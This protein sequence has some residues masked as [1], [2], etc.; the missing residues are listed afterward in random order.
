MEAM[1]R[2]DTRQSPQTGAAPSQGQFQGQNDCGSKAI[3]YEPYF[4]VSG[5]NFSAR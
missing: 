4:Q 1:P 5:R 2:I 3:Q